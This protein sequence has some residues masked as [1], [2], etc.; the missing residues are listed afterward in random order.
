MKLVHLVALALLPA[1]LL[2]ARG[3][4]AANGSRDLQVLRAASTRLGHDPAPEV[5]PWLRRQ[6]AVAGAVLGRDRTTVTIRFRDGSQ[7]DVL[8]R[9]EGTARLARAQLNPKL[10]ARVQGAAR[11]A[12]WEPFAT[13]LGLGPQ[14]GDAEVSMLQGAGFTVDQAYDAQVSVGAMATLPSYNVVY[15]HTHSGVDAGGRGILATGEPANGDPSVAPLLADG[16][17]VVVGVAGSN[18]SYYAITSTYVRT[19]LAPLPANSL[20]FMNGC[21]LL[22]SQEFWNAL[23]ARG[24]GVLV[25]WTA[26]ATVQD[27]FLSGAAFF[28]Q[29]SQGYTVRGALQSLYAA[30]YGKSTSEGQAASLGSLGNGGITLQLA[31]NGQTTTATPTGAVPTATRTPPPTGTSVPTATATPRPTASNTPVPIAT[32]RPTS[33]ATALPVSVSGRLLGA[34]K[35]GR[36]QTIAVLSAANTVVRY[37]VA[38]PNGDRLAGTVTTDG[39]GVAR[40][41][42]MQPASKITRRRN[43]A[44]VTLT[45]DGGQPGAA[46]RQAYLIGFGKIDAVVQPR[47]IVPGRRA[48]L[49]A[50]TVRR[51]A[52]RFTIRAG[53]TVVAA[54]R[55]R[56]GSQGWAHVRYRVPVSTRGARLIVR[57][58]AVRGGKRVHSA[59]WL[60]VS[61]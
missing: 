6:D 61:G 4:R 31:A 3:G 41:G 12:V 18:Q 25:S 49:W 56:T 8:P 20:L 54:R 35:P 5:L 58:D 29:M 34:V 16:S 52:V 36:R 27:D 24:A 32:S 55:A 26:N 7:A 22:A 40:I 53:R 15:M 21:A 44:T 14:A 13:E 57:V 59:T 1:A 38:F 9:E 46:W 23:Q 47:T 60:L 51:T 37:E 11:A 43:A 17:V 50:H 42:F 28:N 10:R 33:T 39:S 19:H 48:T 30:G 2:P 45:V